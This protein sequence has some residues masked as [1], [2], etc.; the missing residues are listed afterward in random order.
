MRSGTLLVLGFVLFAGVAFGLFRV[1]GGRAMDERPP[2][3]PLSAVRDFVRADNTAV[4]ILG[5]IRTIDPI[6]VRGEGPSGRAV[7]ATVIGVR[8]QARIEATL[9]ERGGRW[10][11]TRA[12]LRLPDGRRLPLR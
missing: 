10:I 12:E 3:T 11:V 4:G 6:Q 9:E 2:D 7:S 5:G 1:Y 8:G